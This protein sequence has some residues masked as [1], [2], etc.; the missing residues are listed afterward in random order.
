M[1]NKIKNGKLAA[2]A[3]KAEIA[4]EVKKMLKDGQNPPHLAAVL[5]G[6][7]PASET[8]V[9]AKVKAC[10]LVGFRSTLI[11]F[12]DHIGERELLSKVRELN[13]DKELDGFI[14]Q[15][16]LPEQIGNQ[17]IIEAISPSKDVD[18]FH[19][20][21]IGKL[22]L[23]LPAFISATPGG[24]MEL[25]KR[26]GIETSGKH[27]VVLGRSNI[28]GTP[29]SIL[30]SRKT[31]PGNCTLTLCHSRT[32]DISSYTRQADI[33]IVAIGRHHFVRGD[34]VKDG[35]VVID[36]GM[37]RIPDSSKKSGFALQGDVCFEE[38]APKCSYITPVPGGVGPMTIAYLLKNTLQAARCYRQ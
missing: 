15:L 2:A 35:A 8:Y 20:E 32:K 30:M 7:D 6:H 9:A 34:M 4:E 19:P 36:V 1:T 13:S 5:L 12:E 22:A 37:H 25:F 14:V 16:P 17:S 28:V 38:V 31:E 21:N 3:R 23:G 33:L 10:E 24:I 26:N 11:R 27:C 18:G 29:V